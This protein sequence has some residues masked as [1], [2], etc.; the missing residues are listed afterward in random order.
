GKWLVA[1]VLIAGAVGTGVVMQNNNQREQE[2]QRI[3]QAHSDSVAR[4]QAFVADSAQRADSVLAASTL[5]VAMV[6]TVALRAKQHDDSVTNAKRQ[7]RDGLL[8]GI[9]RYTNAVQQGDLVRARA[10]FPNMSDQEQRQWQNALEKFDLKI[11]VEPSNIALSSHDSVA[12]LDVVLRVQ[13]IDKSTKQPTS[14]RPNRRRATLVR[15][16]SG[17]Q[18]TALTPA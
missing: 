2:R 15:Q 1:L 3:A 13:Y 10:A 4:Q 12:N 9:S 8:G 16:G 7:I 5:P 18:L 6:D 17:W 11:R 14:A